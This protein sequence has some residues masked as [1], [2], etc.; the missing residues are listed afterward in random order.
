MNTALA[1][2]R[3]D[4]LSAAP[5]LDIYRLLMRHA[6]DGLVAGDIAS[7]LGIAANTASFHLKNLQHSGLIAATAEGRFLR[8]RAQ[9]D[10]MSALVGFLTEQCCQGQPARC[11]LPATPPCSETPT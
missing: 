2:K 6:P 4:S 8:Y 11:G 1:L 10:A 3:L 5:R 7:Q 9:L